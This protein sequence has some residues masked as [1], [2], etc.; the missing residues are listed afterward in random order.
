MTRTGCS[1]RWSAP[2]SGWRASSRARRGAHRRPARRPGRRWSLTNPL[3][4]LAWLATAP[5]ARRYVVGWAGRS[6]LHVLAPG[7][8]ARR[9]PPTC[10]ARREM[11]DARRRLPVRAAG[12]RREQPDLARVMPA[13]RLRRE[14]RW[15]WLLEGAA[16]WFGGQTEHARPAI[17]RRLRE[18]GRPSFPPGPRDARAARRHRDRPARPRE[19]ARPPRRAW[20]AACTPRAREAALREAF[21]GRSLAHTE[22]AWRSHLARL[23]ARALS[24]SPADEQQHDQRPDRERGQQA[25]QQPP[26]DDDP[27]RRRVVDQ[28]GLQQ[29]LAGGV[30]TPRSG[31]SRR[32]GRRPACRAR[33]TRRCGA[34]GW[35]RPPRA[36]GPG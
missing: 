30:R 16:R 32:A 11:L 12:D 20:P 1:S 26:R 7:A 4:P 15:A 19:G 34:A 35:A 22:G 25:G 23:A 28:F 13:L 17:A 29:H 18:G 6:E 14:L 8:A 21:G 2:A 33:R 10:R 27:A 5:A 31:P 24:E 9:A 3:L 36:A